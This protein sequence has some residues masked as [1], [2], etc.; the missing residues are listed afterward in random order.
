MLLWSER[1]KNLSLWGWLEKQLQ[2][3][4]VALELMLFGNKTICLVAF[5]TCPTCIIVNKHFIA[6]GTRIL[7]GSYIQKKT[8]PVKVL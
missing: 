7:Y 8:D 5:A 4:T 6:E 2:N 1:E 3:S